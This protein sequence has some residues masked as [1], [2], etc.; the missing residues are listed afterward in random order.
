[1][2]R[3]PADPL[4]LRETHPEL[5]SLLRDP[6]TSSPFPPLLFASSISTL[7]AE[8]YVSS[9]PLSGLV[10]HSPL[11]APL[12]HSKFPQAFKTKLDEFDYEP[13]F[14]VA[15]V[16]GKGKG[17]T[18]CRLVKEFVEEEDEEDGLVRRLVGDRDEAG[19]NKVME[20]M[21]ENGL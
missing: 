16:E 10:L 13:F 1:L 2:P 11:P 21:D 19:W 17:E 15:V 7:L 6:S 9:H 8:T 4:F 12:A 3:T 14:P 18:Q 5:L 20:W